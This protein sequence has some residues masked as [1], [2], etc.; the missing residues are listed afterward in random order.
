MRPFEKLAY[1]HVN[2]AF[3]QVLGDFYAQRY[4]GPEAKEDVTQ[5][6]KNMIAI[7]QKRLET[8]EW[9]SPATREKAILKLQ[10]MDLLVGYPDKIPP[11]YEELVVGDRNWEE[12]SIVFFMLLLAVSTALNRQ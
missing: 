1:S 2:Q 4:F 7:Y 12:I 6:V 9:L 10:K 11:V 3:D 8:K 5:M